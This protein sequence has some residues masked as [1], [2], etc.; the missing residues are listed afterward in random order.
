MGFLKD[1]SDI[2]NLTDKDIFENFSNDLNDTQQILVIVFIIYFS[3][4]FINL[5]LK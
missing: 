5:K 3:Y 2:F 4:I 1:A